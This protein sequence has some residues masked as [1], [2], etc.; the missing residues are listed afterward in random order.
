MHPDDH[1]MI[2]PRLD[3]FHQQEEAPGAVFWHPRGAALY[4]LTESYIRDEM[5]QARYHE[6]RT[7]QLLARALWERSGHLRKFGAHMFTFEDGERSFALKPMSCPAHVEIFR[8]QVRSHRDLPMRF[9]EFGAC[10]RYEP[11]GALHGLL[12]ARAFT[13]D[14]AHVFCLAEHVDGVVAGFC[15]IVR[16]AYARF[17]FPEFSVGLSTRPPDREG[18]DASWDEAEEV[19]ARAA[20]ACGLVFRRQPGEGAFYGPKLEFLLK[21]REG[22]EWQCGTIQLDP[23]LPEN[24]DVEIVQASGKKSHPL[25]IH[26]AVLGSLERFIG[27]VLERH[28]GYLPFWLAPEQV[29]VAPVSSAQ[30]EYARRV[31]NEFG[32]AGLRCALSDSSETLSRRVV[33]AHEQGIPIFATTGAKEVVAQTVTL[34]RPDGQTAAHS[35]PQAIAWLKSLESSELGGNMTGML[36]GSATEGRDGASRR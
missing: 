27:L 26:H 31:A 14:D 23:V 33:S 22:R 10:H 1:R 17:G 25:M 13:Q 21:D 15:D 18:S 9:C 36:A 28:R 4:R 8:Q 11:S 30:Q 20:G 3:L 6:V 24:L 5:R 34:R 32:A 29:A 16:R 35:L 19:L 12:R 7:P 2:G